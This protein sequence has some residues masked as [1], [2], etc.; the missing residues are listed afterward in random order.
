MIALAVKLLLGNLITG[1]L[2]ALNDGLPAGALSYLAE[3]LLI[4]FVYPRVSVIAVSVFGAALSN[5][6]QACI[7][8][9]VIRSSAALA[10]LPY[11][12][13]LG[14]LSGAVVGT[15]VHLNLA[16]DSPEGN[17]E[18]LKLIKGKYFPY[19]IHVRDEKA[20]TRDKPIEQIPAPA[21]VAICVSQH[22]GAPA[23]P[24][25]LRRGHGKKRTAGRGS[26]R[27]ALRKRICKRFRPGRR[28][29][30]TGQPLRRQAEIRAHQKRL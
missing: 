15:A 17:K 21:E 25:A 23:V 26:L 10:Y 3:Y 16:N 6:A 4:R 14:V 27:R 18:V 2:S 22:I 9:A 24:V 13:L 29:G 7:F 8:A 11:L 5:A 30:R 28:R 20:A 12:V 1:N 19:G